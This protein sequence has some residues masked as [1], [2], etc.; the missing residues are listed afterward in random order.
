MPGRLPE[1]SDFNSALTLS[2]TPAPP[3]QKPV[4]ILILLH[5]LGDT[6]VSFKKLGQQLSLPET[7]CL[8]LQ[9]PTPLPLDTGG[10]HWG[11]DLIFDQGTGQLDPDTGFK[12]STEVILQVI[13]TLQD[14][15]GYS[16]RDI[17]FLG[18]GQGG[19]A[20]LN[21]TASIP[22]AGEC[23]GVV[24]I[25][26]PLPADSPRLTRKNK[27]PVL[28]LGGS[29]ETLV[30][31]SSVERLKSTFDFVEYKRWRRPRDSMPRNRDEMMPIMQFFARRLRSRQGVPEGSV[32]L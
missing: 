26:G 7:A 5:G 23:A 3:S 32:E 31:D 19:M 21:A 27:T 16:L 4:N 30:S 10:F 2:I 18:F 29:S 24:S 11:D 9:A 8:S 20:A 25:G 13:K 6:H 14:Q 22:S 1:P 17:I 15:C 12:K 28:V